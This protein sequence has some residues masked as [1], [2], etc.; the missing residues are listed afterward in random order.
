MAFQR[1]SRETEI[2]DA[3]I[4]N[5]DRLGLPGA[6]AIRNVRVAWGFGRIDVMLLPRRGPIRLALIETKHHSAPDAICKVIGQLLMYYAGS[7]SIGAT[8]LDCLRRYA[9]NQPQ[10]AL[11]LNWTSPKELTRG[12]SP[13]TA[14]WHIMQ[15]GAKLQSH[16]IKLFI[17]VSA[18]PHEALGAAVRVLRQHHDLPIGVLVVEGG[19][20]RL[21]EA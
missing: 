3:I 17:A 12:V 21:L 9:D 4:A 1:V 7:L 20:P 8:G 6:S 5:P 13:P 14:A 11:A 19:K 18:Q 15:S 10:K 2:E 16:E